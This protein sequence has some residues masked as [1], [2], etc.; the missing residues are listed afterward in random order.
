MYNRRALNHLFY[1]VLSVWGKTWITGS[2][3]KSCV[4][5]PDLGHICPAAMTRILLGLRLSSFAADEYISEKSPS[6]LYVIFIFFWDRV[7]PT[8][9]ISSLLLLDLDL[10]LEE[11]GVDATAELCLLLVV[12]FVF[13]FALI[14]ASSP[15]FDAVPPIRLILYR[16]GTCS[17]TSL[18]E[19]QNPVPNILKNYTYAA[20]QLSYEFKFSD[21]TL[22]GSGG[23]CA[24]LE[25][26]GKQRDFGVVA[27]SSMDASKFTVANV[28]TGYSKH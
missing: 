11:E 5:F 3:V 18:Y 25:F 14:E 27:R 28:K 21:A 7:V 4:I 24:V 12:V 2:F 15:S 13:V 8:T 19:A 10:E 23:A 9:R 26:S 20:S 17:I 6:L 22:C 1:F 16:Q